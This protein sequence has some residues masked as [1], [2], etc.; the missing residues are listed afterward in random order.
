MCSVLC[1][2][3]GDL[4]RFYLT[5]VSS[6]VKEQ[7]SCKEFAFFPLFSQWLD[8]K[9]DGG[10][11]VVLFLEFRTQGDSTIFSCFSHHRQVSNFWTPGCRHFINSA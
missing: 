1:W 2:Q 5:Y 10:R 9:N 7:V 3:W 6:Y 11:S 8:L 4:S